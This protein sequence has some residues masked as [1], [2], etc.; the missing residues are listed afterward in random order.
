MAKWLYFFVNKFK[1]Y[2]IKEIYIIIYSKGKDA[3]KMNNN[4]YDDLK[5]GQ[6]YENIAPKY[7]NYKTIRFSVGKFSA[8]DFILDEGTNEECKVEVKLD[9]MASKTGNLAIEYKCSGK[10][11]GIYVTEAKYYM[12][13]IN[14]Y[15]MADEVYKI[16]VKDLKEIC[17]S[18]GHKTSGGDR[19][20]S[21]MYLVKKE[22]VSN[23]MIKEVLH[24]PPKPIQKETPKT[25][26]L[27][28]MLVALKLDNIEIVK[29]CIYDFRALD[30]PKEVEEK[31]EFPR[32]C[33]TNIMTFGKHKGKEVNE[34]A[35]FDLKYLKWLHNQKWFD[36][37]K[38]LKEI[39]GKII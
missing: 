31:E 19:N 4:F 33:K 13:F 8:Y 35:K 27:I 28:D 3:P 10:P 15:G 1:Y 14:Y 7:F 23:Y 25:D 11:S 18:K 12:Y 20:A 36:K 29:Q 16:P 37:F 34:I 32:I 38:D 22:F 26:V 2:Y 9:C 21:R 30:K 5:K 6:Q 24:E 17:K 39:V